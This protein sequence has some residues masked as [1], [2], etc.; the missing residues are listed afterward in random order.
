MPL[1]VAGT[2]HQLITLMST[3]TQRQQQ[4]FELGRE[5]GEGAND[6]CACVSTHMLGESGGMLPQENL[7]N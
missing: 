3:V 5:G 1:F 2:E 7:A 6:L 4:T